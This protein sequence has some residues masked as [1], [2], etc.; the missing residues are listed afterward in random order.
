MPLS[1]Q[2]IYNNALFG[3]RG[4]NYAR[5][6]TVGGRCVYRGDRGLKCALGHSIPDSEYTER[7]DE[8]PTLEVW[9]RLQDYIEFEE[10]T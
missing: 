1:K 9:T 4:Q 2:E 3:I 6:A 8:L 7:L 10:P 5:S